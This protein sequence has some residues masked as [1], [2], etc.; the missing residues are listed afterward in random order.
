MGSSH[1]DSL[2]RIVVIGAGIVG[3]ALADELTARGHTDVTVVDQGPLFSTGGSSSHAP[4][5]VFRTN[6]SKALTDFAR[7][8]VEKYLTLHHP[9]GPCF[10]PVGGLEVATTPQRWADL[11]RK[12]GLAASWGVQDA[13]LVDAEQCV[14]LAPLLD[15][16]QVLGGLHTATDGLADAV[17]AGEAQA[18]RAISRGA[19]FLARHT[20]TGVERHG[21]AV[22]G[23]RTQHGVLPADVVVCAAGFWGRE[24]AELAETPLPLLPL[25]HQYATSAALPE[26]RA[27]RASSGPEQRPILR[28]QDRDLYF[29]E[30]DERLGIGSYA[31]RPLPAEPHDGD[32]ELTMPSMREFTPEDFVASWRDATELLPALATSRVEEGFNGVFSFTPDGMPLVGESRQLRGFFVAE[33]VWVT[34][35]AGVARAVAELLTDGRSSTDLHSSALYRFD[36]AECAP[37]S[38]ECRGRQGFVE[39]YDVTHPWQPVT[40]PRPLRVSPF[41]HRQR[42]L[43]ARMD[44]GSGWER[45]QWYETNA[46]LLD[47]VHVPERDTWSAR[48]WS[49]I[50]VAE[51]RAT[52]QG[53]ALFD[54]TPLKRLEVSGP[55][56]ARFLDW[57]TTNRLR[58]PGTVSYTLLLDQGG[59]V[60]SDLTV[61]RLG[62]QRFQVGCNGERD[63][64][65]LLRHA[66][67]DG[68][69]HVRDLTPGTC[70]VGVW[71]P[72]ARD[73][74]RPLGGAEFSSSGFGY[75]RARETFV[76]HV[77]VTALR[78]SYVGELGWELYTTAELGA[79]LWD[80]L[81]SAGR[82]HGVIAAGRAALDSLRLEKGFRS[83]GRD[84]TG[85]H[86]PHEAGLGFAVRM[87][88]GDFL[89]RAALATAGQEPARHLLTCFTLNDPTD[90]VLGGEPVYADGDVVGYVT[91][92]AYGAT[93]GRC[94][95]YAWLRPQYAAVSTA[96]SVEY[97][98]QRHAATVV[99]EPL[100]TAEASGIRQ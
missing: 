56:A 85:E 71:G 65:W 49:P 20:V 83:W 67:D 47:T 35:S 31:H 52:R 1:T 91:S 88:K 9:D 54:M 69:V 81:F 61:A 24:V 13:Q 43:G 58:R 32:D 80:V 23:V 51:A 8:T 76:E 6:T 7:Y 89:G 27:L 33:A 78:V 21:A 34:H 15:K 14:R 98:G 100:V 39:I 42:E 2:P 96:V 59:G 82:E 41:H 10:R 18:R 68:S 92:A 73:L 44:Y 74:V 22:S 84:V 29:R 57:M 26:L 99:A 97:F 87:D 40:E 86:G 66:P 93:V 55:Q 95:G 45:P 3:C 75:F 5:L 53:V 46:S 11:H 12:A 77:P 16:N 36:P 79:R 72:R 28:H 37:A 50:A 25:A 48:H 4:G 62:E 90:Q 70:C 19:V 60:L 30:H 94:V 63:L 38:V 17:R 64:D